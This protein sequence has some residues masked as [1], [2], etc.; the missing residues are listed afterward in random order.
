MEAPNYR[1]ELLKCPRF[2][3][4]LGVGRVTLGKRMQFSF[5][6]ASLDLANVMKKLLVAIAVL[7]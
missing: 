5:I 3:R 2:R 6:P 7:G 1:N 4:R